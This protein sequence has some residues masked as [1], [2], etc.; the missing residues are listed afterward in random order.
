MQ[1][2]LG[3]ASKR[4]LTSSNW[5]HTCEFANG[6]K[7]G[8]GSHEDDEESPKHTSW[9]AIEQAADGYCKNTLPRNQHSARKSKQR[10]EAEATLQEGLLAQTHQVLVIAQHCRLRLGRRRRTRRGGRLFQPD[11]V[12]LVIHLVVVAGAEM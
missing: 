9:T 2:L 12:L 10:H 8:K 5:R 11:I 4:T 6:R 1:S 3:C 7:G